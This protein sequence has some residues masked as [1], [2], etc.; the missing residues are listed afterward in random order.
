MKKKM[1]KLLVLLSTLGASTQA[2]T[3]VS[4][5]EFKALQSRVEELEFE[6][7][8]KNFS[9]SGEIINMF[10][11]YHNEF[12]SGSDEGEN[13][14][15]GLYGT[16]VKMNIDFDVNDKINLYTTLGMS[17]FW[18]NEDRAGDAND[19]W[20]KSNQGSLGYQG[21]QARFDKVFFDYKMNDM[22][23]F[24]VG[25][26]PTNFGPPYHQLDNSERSGTYPRMAYNS[27]FDGVAVST[28]LT[29]F[30]P[31]DQTLKVKLFYTPYMNVNDKNRNVPRREGDKPGTPNTNGDKVQSNTLLWAF[32]LEHSVENLSWVKKMDTYLFTLNYEDFWWEEFD[33]TYRGW[34][35]NYT[36]GLEGLLNTGFNFSYSYIGT[37]WQAFADKK[38]IV[39]RG[40]LFNLNYKFEN[41]HAVGMEYLVTNTFYYLDEWT[42]Y[43]IA[44]FY[45]A[46]KM[47]GYHFFWSLPVYDN[48]R[49]RLGSYL[50]EQK[51]DTGWGITGRKVDSHY[52]ML[53][54]SF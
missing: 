40:Q 39:G 33:D 30:V 51:E 45:K 4:E 46:G 42:Y 28:D 5:A 50:Y 54:L 25:R 1:T 3:A 9:L 52:A 31:K 27:I 18:N 44:D 21:S 49:L 34:G 15:L 26:M 23:T 35:Y 43:N 8:T 11:M 12:T 32:L 48:L 24:A 36:L 29:R 47:V 6:S 17:K 16:A 22:F 13:Y 7:Y 2:Y 37:D 53:K 38:R 10:E 14:H 20:N 41:T 19:Y